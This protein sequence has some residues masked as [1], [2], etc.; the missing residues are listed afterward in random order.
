MRDPNYGR[1]LAALAVLMLMSAACGGESGHSLKVTIGDDPAGEGGCGAT[2]YP[3]QRISGGRV[4]VLGADGASLDSAQL[5]S[6]GEARQGTA[7]RGAGPS[8]ACFWSVQLSVAD[9][10]VYKVQVELP[11]GAPE[12]LTYSQAELEAMEW[13][14]QL[15]KNF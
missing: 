2:S 4:T 7:D 5:P 11:K 6:D 10:K 1:R 3:G 9:S 8:E 13:H 12:T 14:L 15:T